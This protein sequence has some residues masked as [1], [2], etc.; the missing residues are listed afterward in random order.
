MSPAISPLPPAETGPAIVRRRLDQVIRRIRLLHTCAGASRLA[1]LVVV[2]LLAAYGLDR[3]LDLPRAVRTLALLAALVLMSRE[4]WRRLLRPLLRGPDRLDAARLV[5]GALSFE[6]R[7]ISSLQLPEG[8][9]GSLEHK[10]ASETSEACERVDLRVVLTARPSMLELAR[11]VGAVVALALIMVLARPHTSVF[12]QRWALADVP[13]PRDTHLELILADEGPVHIRD[14]DSVIAARAGTLSVQAGWEGRRPDRV[15]LVVESD[16][17]ERSTNL[18]LG[19]SGLFQGHFTVE[20]G[21]LALRIRGGDDNGEDNR[22][23]LLVIEPPRLDNPEFVLTPPE[24]IGDPPR[25]VGAADLVV[26]EGTLVRLEGHPRGTASSATLWMQARGESLELDVSDDEQGQVVSGSF[27][28]LE[29]DTL[30]VR[31]KGD[32][33]LATPEPG[34]IALLV[35]EDRAPTLRVYAP[36]RSDVKVTAQAVVPVAVMA[37]DDHGVSGVALEFA[38][39]GSLDLEADPDDP[40]QHRLLLDLAALGLTDTLSYSLQALDRRQLGDRGPQLV[41]VE[42]RRIDVVEVAELQRLMADRQ[43]RLKED[44]SLIKDRQIRAQ[45]V[46]DDLLGDPPEIGDPDLLVAAVAQNQVTARLTR[47]TRELCAILDETILN[48]LDAG[49]GA[50]VLLQRR[51]ADWKDQPVDE[52]YSPGV[53]SALASDYGAG[54]FGRLDVVGRLLDMAALALKLGQ[55]SS[56]AAHDLLVAARQDPTPD[57]LREARVAQEAVI[58]DLSNLLDRMDEWEDYQEVITLVKS[59]IDDQ[60]A[61]RDRSQQVLRKQP[62]SN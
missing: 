39:G 60:R 24:Y 3:L 30:T 22:V 10:L 36:P 51:L 8:Q 54:R 37:Q 13:W 27:L 26:S 4:L 48:R 29:S 47:E 35:H 33:G 14:G 16:M 52:P 19:S 15:E 34:R 49:P 55:S 32:H 53:W 59:L 40:P 46:V 18:S 44:Y 42:G 57:R 25:R 58:T 7:L 23:V 50:E 43:L 5:E 56:P 17:G 62:G 2:G 6:G 38:S 11:A 45:E 9:P 31:L 1:S 20:P 61:L 12:L 21:D 28:A 41:R